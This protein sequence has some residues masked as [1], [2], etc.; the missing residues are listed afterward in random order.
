M[1]LK[2]A[3]SLVPARTLRHR[4][5]RVISWRR[6]MVPRQ[7]RES[8]GPVLELGAGTGRRITLGIARDG[9]CTRSTPIPRCST[10]CGRSWRTEP[11]EAQACVRVTV[12]DMRVLFDKDSDELVIEAQ[13][14]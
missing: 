7:G 11:R 4:Y 10:G 1:S 5:T 9:V 12:G 13:A 3:R 2:D 6:R 14:D 8:G